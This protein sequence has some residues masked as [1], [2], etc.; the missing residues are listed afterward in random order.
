MVKDQGPGLGRL[1]SVSP[2]WERRW[3]YLGKAARAASGSATCAL[4]T[5]PEHHPH[6]HESFICKMRGGRSDLGV[7]PL[8]PQKTTG[9]CACACVRA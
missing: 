4:S 1:L 9:M 8:A 2:T 6:A 3:V 7:N 5:V